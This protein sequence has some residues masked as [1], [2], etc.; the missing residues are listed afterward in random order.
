MSADNQLAPSLDLRDDS[1]AQTVGVGALFRQPRMAGNNRRRGAAAVEFAIVAPVLILLLMGMFEFGRTLM[2]Q[3]ILTNGAREG[4]RKS[5]LPG[6]TEANVLSTIDSYMS[7]SGLAG[8]TRQVSPNPTSAQTGD[9]IRVTVS[10]P[11]NTVSWLPLGLAGHLRNATLSASVEMRK[12][13]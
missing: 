6:A 13:Q 11:Y 5:V 3:Q 1:V 7:S 2:V 4:A 12:E 9:P 10:I 8:H